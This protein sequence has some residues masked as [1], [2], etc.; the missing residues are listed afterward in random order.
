MA[1]VPKCYFQVLQLTMQ[2]F[3]KYFQGP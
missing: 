3:L 1:A 2:G